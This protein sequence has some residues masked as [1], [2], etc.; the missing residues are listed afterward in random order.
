MPHLTPTREFAA[1]TEA[2][3]SRFIAHLIPMATWE[4][5]LAELAVQHRKASHICTATRE[6]ADDNSVLERARDDGEPGGT[7]GR[8][9]LAVIAGAGVVG[10][11]IAVVRYFGGTK[12][13]TGGLARAY[14]GAAAEALAIAKLTEW[15]RIGSKVLRAGFADASALEQVIAALPLTVMNRTHTEDG[16]TLRVQGPEAALNDPVLTPWATG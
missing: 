1:E 2:K 6:V 3:G 7:A 9:I 4:A 14:G 15:H 5:R 12:L 10:A 8:P 16:T 11:G 13:G